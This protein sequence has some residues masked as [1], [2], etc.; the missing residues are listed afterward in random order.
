MPPWP[1]RATTCMPASRIAPPDTSECEAAYGAGAE[2]RR[3]PAENNTGT[4][5][6][7]SVPV[8]WDRLR[9]RFHLLFSPS[10]TPEARAER[11]ASQSEPA[12]SS[13]VGGPRSRSADRSSEDVLATL[14]RLAELHRRGVMTEEEFTTK[15]AE[16]LSRI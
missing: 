2:V 11:P 9:G 14:E 13:Q 5:Q 15:K 10:S 16:L 6:S 7:R 3:S 12:A 8:F 1:P 4:A